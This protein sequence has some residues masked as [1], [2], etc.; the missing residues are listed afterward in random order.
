MIK[1]A[2]TPE[3]RAEF[4]KLNRYC[5]SRYPSYSYYSAPATSSFNL[6]S[7]LGNFITITIALQL[8]LFFCN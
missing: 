8:V 2:L 5:G 7:L 3:I 1:V 4:Q 6:A